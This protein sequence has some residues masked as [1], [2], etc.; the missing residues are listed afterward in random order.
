[1]KG[2]S[3]CSNCGAPTTPLTEICPKCGVR[4]QKVASSPTW[5]STLAGIL[6]IVAG[7]IGVIGGLGLVSFPLLEEDIVRR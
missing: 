4:P 1:M 3:F 2:N 6:D 5:K 7:V